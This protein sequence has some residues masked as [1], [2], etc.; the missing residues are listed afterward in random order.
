MRH[1]ITEDQGIK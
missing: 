1:N